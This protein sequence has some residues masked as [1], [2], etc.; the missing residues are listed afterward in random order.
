MIVLSAALLAA[1]GCRQPP[2]PPEVHAALEG[3][4]T[5]MGG[6]PVHVKAYDVTTATHAAAFEEV[7]R[8]VERLEATMSVYQPASPISRAN[9]GEAVALDD[10]TAGVVAA[11]L[12]LAEETGGAFD[13][14]VKPVLAL[15]KAATR[16]GEVPTDAAL[17]AAR[18]RTGI[19]RIHLDSRRGTTEL[20][21]DSGAALDLGGIAKGFFA[22]VGVAVLRRHGVRRG[23]VEL[24]GDL[25]VFDDRT[26]PQPFRL[27]VRHPI[28]HGALLGSVEVSGGGVVTSGDYER[29]YLIGDR[30]FN[31]IVDPRT[32]RPTEGVHSVTLVAA[33]GVRADALATGVLVMGAGPGMAFVERTPDVEAVMVVADPE[34]AEGWRVV[35]SSGLRD[36]LRPLA[37][38]RSAAKATDERG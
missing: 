16:T 27:G 25:V 1:L 2:P 23:L 24:G 34:A 12:R 10:E 29:G 38:P 32:G 21:L 4:F 8:E 36:K 30:R 18:A 9:A 7:R 14:T 31:H 22:D 33:T 20:R 15:W 6:I 11:A 3:E 19:A 5:A 26:R 35:V 13:P 28:Q 37:T 17:G